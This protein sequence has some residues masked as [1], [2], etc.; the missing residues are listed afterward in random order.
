MDTLCSV[1]IWNEKNPGA[2]GEKT[3]VSIPGKGVCAKFG[4]THGMLYGKKTRAKAGAFQEQS[5]NVER[6]LPLTG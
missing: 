5:K 1:N 6:V 3:L 4:M 2:L